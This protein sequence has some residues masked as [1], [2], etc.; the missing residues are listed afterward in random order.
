MRKVLFILSVC[1]VLALGAARPASADDPMATI[2]GEKLER[3]L[4]NQEK[5]LAEL[6]AIKA[7]LA[8]VKVRA[9]LGT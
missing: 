5:I 3:V 4:Q 8:V 9:T 6:E 1:S 2:V 7:E